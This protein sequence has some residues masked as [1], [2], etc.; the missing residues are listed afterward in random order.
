VAFYEKGQR[1]VLVNLLPNMA[2]LLNVSVEELLRLDNVATKRGPTLKLQRQ[3]ERLSRLSRSRQ[4]FVLEILE[5][6]LQQAS[7]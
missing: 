4:R 5:T 3:L 6:V 1:R 2:R 7:R